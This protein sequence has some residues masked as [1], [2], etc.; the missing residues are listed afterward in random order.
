M[1]YHWD[2]NE[3]VELEVCEKA[4]KTPTPSYSQ[5]DFTDGGKD[6]RY[7]TT[8]PILASVAVPSIVSKVSV[9]HH[10]QSSL[11]FVI[12]FCFDLN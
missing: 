11:P 1:D 5:I 10:T 9:I 12:H 7:N 6:A 3:C 4:A 8:H 2:V